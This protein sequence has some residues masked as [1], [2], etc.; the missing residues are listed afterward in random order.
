VHPAVGRVIVRRLDELRAQPEPPAAVVIEAIKLLEGGLARLC[1]AV[2]VVDA[3]RAVQIARLVQTRGLSP[4][5][6]E[7]RIDAQPPAELKR[8]RAD[9]LI[10][11]DGSLEHLRQ[12]VLEAWQQTV[13]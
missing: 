1:D 10:V 5:E 3:P 8:A 12:Q 9:V 2:W 13:Q 6:A 11:N 7:A 4:Q